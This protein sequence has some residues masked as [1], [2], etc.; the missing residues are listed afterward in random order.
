MGEGKDGQSTARVSQPEA[1]DSEPGE[2]T[3]AAFLSS[4]LVQRKVRTQ[5]AVLIAAG[6]LAVLVGVV[7]LDLVG[8]FQ[9]PGMGAV[10]E[11]A[12]VKP[13]ASVQPITAGPPSALSAAEK[14]ALRRKML[15]QDEAPAVQRTARPVTSAEDEITR[16]L[17]DDRRKT[18]AKVE[19]RPVTALQAPNLPSGLT[20]EVIFKVIGE[21][22]GAISLC[23]AK[24][25][26]A[27]EKLSGKMAVEMT[28]ASTGRV[29][30]VHIPGPKFSSTVMG[31][32]TKTTVRRWRFPSFPGE[33]VTVVF[34][35]VLSAGF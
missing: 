16:L 27:G 34:P 3:R 24:A 32:C 17:F 13:S 22:Q 6:L 2:E 11:L 10:R 28:V 9:V 19:L 23:I 12:G 33:E 26:R 15:G 30:A 35:Y 4:G 21:G 20:R 1:D 25:M 8:V 7:L 18:E 14:E 5:R 29:A 31:E